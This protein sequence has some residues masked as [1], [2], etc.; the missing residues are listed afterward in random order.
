MRRKEVGQ[1]IVNRMPEGKS[2]ENAEQI[3]LENIA[4]EFS[5]FVK[6]VNLPI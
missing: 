4:V 3:K 6:I 1:P 5:N 2:R